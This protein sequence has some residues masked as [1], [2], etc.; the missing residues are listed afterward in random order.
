MF[1]REIDSRG[2]DLADFDVIFAGRAG[3]YL[4]RYRGWH[5]F[6]SSLIVLYVTALHRSTLTCS[7]RSSLHAGAACRARSMLRETRDKPQPL[8]P[9]ASSEIGLS[10]AFV[11]FNN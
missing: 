2:H 4:L 8:L 11:T 1:H 5:I 10:P 3:E 6:V 7:A 9:G